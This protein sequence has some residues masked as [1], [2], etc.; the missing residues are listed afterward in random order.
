MASVKP[1]GLFVRLKGY[2]A[3]GLVHLSQVW[4]TD[5]LLSMVTHAC[6]RPTA[7]RCRE[8]AAL[9]CICCCCC[10]HVHSLTFCPCLYPC[11]LDASMCW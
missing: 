6:R 3:N 4:G 8:I 2:R 5:V 9:L 1:F 7:I 10:G 11:M